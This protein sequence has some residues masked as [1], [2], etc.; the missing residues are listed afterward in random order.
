V[1]AREALQD[2]FEVARLLQENKNR[3]R[4]GDNSALTNIPTYQVGQ[5]L[6]L[7]SVP[8]PKDVL[9]PK[10]QAKWTGPWFVQ[11]A[12]NRVTVDISREAPQG[13][14]GA[15]T[16][17]RRV[18]VSRVKA[19]VTA[20]EEPEPTTIGELT[21]LGVPLYADE[22]TMLV[23]GTGG[24]RELLVVDAI[25]RRKPGRG[26]KGPHNLLYQLRYADEVA[27]HRDWH[28]RRALMN[29]SL[30]QL[31][32]QYDARFPNLGLPTA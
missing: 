14:Q 17:T 9:V 8:N 13:G 27:P 31:V 32:D 6:W 25:V 19:Y 21:Y 3:R 18:H 22:P 24:S 23:D 2:A 30:L 11:R 12:V 7:A 20:A 15:A 5:A 26:P 4:E 16:D 29:R 28:S 10:L 1:R